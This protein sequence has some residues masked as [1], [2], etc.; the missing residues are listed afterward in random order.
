KVRSQYGY[1]YFYDDVHSI[2]S[3]TNPN[4]GVNPNGE[5]SIGGAFSSTKFSY[6]IVDFITGLRYDHFELSGS[7]AVNA[8]NPLG[9]PAGP[10]TVDRSEGRFNPKITLALNP[11]QW[12][13]PFVTYAETMRA[14]TV[15]E[16]LMGGVH[17]GGGP[18]NGFSPN[19]FLDPEISKGW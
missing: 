12:F 6:G 10:Y 11:T 4:Q 15:S 17:P 13:M 8:N 16:T 1:E 9:M 18:T 2:N 3:A 19:P 5:S 7:G 14:P